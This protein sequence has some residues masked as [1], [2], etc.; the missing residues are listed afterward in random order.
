MGYDTVK[1][2]QSSTEEQKA[3]FQQNMSIRSLV[4]ILNLKGNV[5]STP[6]NLMNGD[7]CC[8]VNQQL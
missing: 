6:S 2:I 5:K 7:F 3:Y 4:P 1:V 8:E